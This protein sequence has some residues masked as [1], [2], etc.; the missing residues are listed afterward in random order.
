MDAT[1]LEMLRQLQEDGRLPN[2]AL[3]ELVHLSPSP[4]LRRLKRLEQD[5]TIRGY[6]A[7]LD[8]RKVGL[9]LTVFVEVKLTGHSQQRADEFSAAIADID[10]VVAAHIVAGMSDFLLEVVV[11]DLAAYEQLLLETLLELPGVTDVRSNIAIRTVK[12]AGPLPL[13]AAAT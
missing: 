9:G 13:D 6:R 10:A 8:R 4:S 5:D 3:A 1:D 12:E 11:P 7:I 2:A